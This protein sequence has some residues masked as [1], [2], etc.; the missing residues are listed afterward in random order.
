MISFQKFTDYFKFYKGLEHQNKGLKELYDLLV[1]ENSEAL[2][3]NAGWMKTYSTANVNKPPI[4]GTSVLLTVPYQKQLDNA[5]GQG[6]RECFSSSCA[7]VAMYYK[8]VKNDDEYNKI[9]AKYGDSTSA[10]AQVKALRSLGISCEFRMDGTTADLE[11][12]IREGKPT[13]V[14][15]LHYGTPSNPVG[16]GHWTAA[17]G[18]DSLHWVMNDPY[19]EADVV[20]GGYLN[21]SNGQGIRYSR[22]NW[23]P[24][25][26]VR[27]TGG[28]YIKIL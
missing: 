2:N 12:Q 23:N 24:R 7:M 27:N 15:W 9:R 25:W 6:Q 10:D 26:R 22:K 3:D 5:S 18:F 17:T 8:K 4:T 19:G 20:N 28:W 21:H 13:P 1:K 16:S 14:G 11:R